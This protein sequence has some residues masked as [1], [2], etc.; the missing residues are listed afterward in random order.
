MNQTRITSHDQQSY[1]GFTPLP[2]LSSISFEV[3]A[4]VQGRTVRNDSLALTGTPQ[5]LIE[6][7]AVEKSWKGSA[8]LIGTYDF[9]LTVSA[10]R[11]SVLWLSFSI[12]DYITSIPHHDLPSMRHI[13]HAGFAVAEAPAHR[14][15]SEFYELL[16]HPGRAEQIAA[17]EPPPTVSGSDAP[18]HRTLDSLPAPDSGGGR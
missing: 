16:S 6:L 12:T 13:L 1:I 18:V 7:R 10:V 11:P 14:Q 5:F 15:F 9:N 3:I 17:H 2:E 8:K 4:S